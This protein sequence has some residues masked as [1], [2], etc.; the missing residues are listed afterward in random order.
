MKQQRAV[1][2]AVAAGLVVLGLVGVGLVS[3]GRDGSSGDA[4]PPI[5]LSGAARNAAGGEASQDKRAATSM[6]AEPGIARYNRPTFVVAGDLPALGGEAAV[7]RYPAGFA[8]TPAQAAQLAAAL[9]VTAPV[10]AVPADQGGGWRAGPIDG[11]GPSVQLGTDAMGSWWY[12]GGPIAGQGYGGCAVSSSGIVP[13]DQQ[14]ADGQG[15]TD[16]A[17]RDDIA[18][19]PVAPLDPRPPVDPMPPVECVTPPPPANVPSADDALSLAR[20][21]FTDLGYD[22]GDW[23]L[24]VQGD[25]YGR[26]VSGQ[27]M[28]DGLVVPVGLYVSYGPDALV[29]GASGSLAEPERLGDYP[30]VDTSTALDRLRSDDPRWGYGYSG[31]PMPMASAAA[32]KEAE[33]GS[34]VAGGTDATGTKPAPD[35]ASTPAGWSPAPV[36]VQ[37]PDAPPPDALPPD[38][39]IE[40]PQVLE[41]YVVTVTGVETTLTMIWQPD[42]AVL[43]VPGYAFLA[44]D[45]GRWEVPAVEDKYIQPAPLPTE[46]TTVPSTDMSSTDVSSTAVPVATTVVAPPPTEPVDTVPATQPAPTAPLATTPA[47]FPPSTEPNGPGPAVGP[48]TTEPGRVVPVDPTASTLDP[49]TTGPCPGTDGSAVP[50]DTT[51]PPTPQG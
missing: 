18:V 24:D 49:A 10:E 36:P 12:G 14:V 15:S 22:L 23:R 20:K 16:A 9:G 27:R 11:T 30:L 17:A 21:L 45:G 33:S 25:E 50:C 48:T 41:P 26:T 43:L 4:L 37:P 7:Y 32:A 31:G 34:G 19:T 5:D 38:V 29:V 35:G 3:V 47:A 8:P 40:P 39:T 44:A 42:G 46:E 6:I 28:L 1:V 51:E 2:G 13:P